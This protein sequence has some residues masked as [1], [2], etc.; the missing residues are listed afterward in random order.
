VDDTPI[1]APE[2][3]PLAPIDPVTWVAQP[4]TTT[5]PDTSATAA[6]EPIPV[7]SDTTA[8]V[9]TP[10]VSDTTQKTT[11]IYD[12]INTPDDSSNAAAI[13]Q[14]STTAPGA[15]QDPVS[16][17]AAATVTPIT[18]ETSAVEFAVVTDSHFTPGNAFP[19]VG[20]IE[21]TD[22]IGIPVI[23]IPVALQNLDP[24]VTP[25]PVPVIVLA[26]TP[27]VVPEEPV[28]PNAPV[29]DASPLVT[30]GMDTSEVSDK[31]AGFL[32]AIAHYMENMKP[33]KP[34]TDAD[35][36][37]FQINLYRALT[38]TINHLEGEDFRKVFTQL[39]Q[40]FHEHEDGV[41]GPTR[42]MRFFETMPLAASERVAF[43]KLVDMF[44]L[45][46]DPKSREVALK[47]ISFTRA[48]AGG[49]TEE[50]RERVKAYFNVQ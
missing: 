44:K 12:Y 20:I 42:I 43:Q 7:V 32:H 47:Q 27:A 39:L 33:K 16:P 49:V 45:L 18:P 29:S 21:P 8:T 46:A 48:L 38:G 36:A 22:V 34:V 10:V 25:D 6:A 50:G 19:S 14:A 30:Y 26:P 28:T 31:G 3:I 41:F 40:K 9:E 23:P 15:T 2:D 1:V 35:G 5:T 4:G 24:V 17:E 37:R 11:V 13:D